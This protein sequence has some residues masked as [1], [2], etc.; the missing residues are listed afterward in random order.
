MSYFH[1]ARKAGVCRSVDCEENDYLYD[2]PHLSSSISTS[3]R[4]TSYYEIERKMHSQM[5]YRGD[6]GHPAP[7]VWEDLSFSN[8][9]AA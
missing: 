3:A 5:S 6:G 1:A 2:A 8:S 7:D 9:A 4:G